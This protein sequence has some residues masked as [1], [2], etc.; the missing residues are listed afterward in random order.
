MDQSVVMTDRVFFRGARPSPFLF[1]EQ[2]DFGKQGLK[3]SPSSLPLER[4]PSVEIADL[5]I[6]KAI[7]SVNTQNR[8]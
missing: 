2:T 6:Q 7:H 3:A 5:V 1:T 8:I 4:E